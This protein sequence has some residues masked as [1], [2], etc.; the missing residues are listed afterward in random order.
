[1]ILKDER[2]GKEKGAYDKIKIQ[3][4]METG[5]NEKGNKKHQSGLVN[6]VLVILYFLS[7]KSTV[8]N[9]CAVCS[10]VFR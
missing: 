9:S 7:F 4:N 3:V 1:M 10:G 6:I 8:I 5:C 2:I